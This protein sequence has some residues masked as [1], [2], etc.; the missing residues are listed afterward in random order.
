MAEAALDKSDLGLVL[1]VLRHFSQRLERFK[2]QQEADKRYTGVYLD[3]IGTEINT[4]VNLTNRIKDMEAIEPKG[5]TVEET[6]LLEK[7]IGLFNDDALK[8][9]AEIKNDFPRLE[10]KTTMLDFKLA[11]IKSI[12]DKLETEA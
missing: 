2:N 1:E 9:K 5:L 10:L 7:G 4:I 3:D 8:F 11:Q 12:K 6:T